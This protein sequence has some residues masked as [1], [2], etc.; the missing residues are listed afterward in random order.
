MTA[1]PSIGL[2]LDVPATLFGGRT[3]ALVLLFVAANR[4]GYATQIARALGMPVGQVQRQL[5]KLEAG[6][7]LQARSVGRTRLFSM[8]ER[9]PFVRDLEALLRRA[10]E[11]LPDAQQRQLMVRGRPRKTGKG[12]PEA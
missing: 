1:R 6:D 5:L 12:L 7:V 9:L 4:E 11:Y 2:S 3:A 10:L 8:N